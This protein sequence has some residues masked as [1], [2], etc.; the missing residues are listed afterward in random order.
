[1]AN[2][3][4]NALAVILG[5]GAGTRLYPL[6]KLR[7]KPAVP[8]AGKYRIIDIPISNCINSGIPRIFVLTQYNSASLNRH[9]SNAYRFDNFNQGFVSIL[10]AEQ[11]PESAEWF[12]G[13]ADAVR[14]TIHHLRAFR[15]D[16]VIILSGD[17]LYQMD[18]RTI[19]RHHELRGAD[20]TIATIPVS[21]E[22][23][24]AF[25]IL[26]T[27]EEGKITEFHEKPEPDEL[28]GLESPVSEDMENVGRVYLASMGIYIFNRDIL[29]EELSADPSQ[30]DFGNEI[31]PAAMARRKIMSYPFEG[32]WSDIGTIRSFYE[33]NLQLAGKHPA[34]DLYSSKLPTYTNARMLAPAKIQDS[35]VKD[36]I[37]SEGSIV[38]DSQVTN[39]VVGIRSLIRKNATVKNS[40][41]MGTDYMPWH[42]PSVRGTVE[43]PDHPGIGEECYIENAI[44]DKNVKIGNNCIIKNRDD[45]TEGEGENF[46]VR[47]GIVIL[48]KNTVLSEGTII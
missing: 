17:Q 24:P 45:I 18:Y 43:G 41:I 5:G 14:Q 26:K 29:G 1:M 23:A 33:A 39:S 4:P 12:Q 2:I 25:G 48:P 37:I 47:D 9:I 32:Y 20:I 10:A 30:H 31:I 38:I 27:D 13:T 8:L 7:S 6:T 16:H 3:S 46:F 36:S 21:A 35:V 40:I 42:D 28:D 44:I 15:H 11:T 22:E 19:L 34:Y